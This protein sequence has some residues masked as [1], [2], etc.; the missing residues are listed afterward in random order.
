MIILSIITLG[1]YPGF[2][3]LNRYKIFNQFNTPHKFS[4]NPFYFYI[5][6]AIISI[7]IEFFAVGD[8]KA[9]A[10][11][12]SMVKGCNSLCGIILM[13]SSIKVGQIFTDLKLN[14]SKLEGF[15]YLFLSL[16]YI[17]HKINKL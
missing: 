9:P 3:F 7:L 17:Q 15:G 1:I 13:F 8:P 10:D 4:P 2:Y 12:A 6:L 14:E 16:F 5:F 11:I